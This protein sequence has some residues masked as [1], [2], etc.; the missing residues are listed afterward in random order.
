ME[1]RALLTL[2]YLLFPAISLANL[3]CPKATQAPSDTELINSLALGNLIARP[4]LYYVDKEDQRSHLFGTTHLG[5]PLINHLPA[6]VVLA[7]R[8]SKSLLVE[9]MP[10]G[11]AQL[12]WYNQSQSE[13]SGQ[14]AEALGPAMYKRYVQLA[15]KKKLDEPKAGALKPWA[16]MLVIGSP[17]N[18]GRGL[19]Q[20]ILMQARSAGVQIKAMQHL[21]DIAV[22]LD[23]LS[24]SDQ[25]VMLR[26]TIC[27]SN[28][29]PKYMRQLARIYSF[30]NP[31]LLHRFNH[32]GR[33]SDPVFARFDKALVDNRNTVF[34]PTILDKLKTGRVFI[35]VGAEHLVGVN[36]LIHQLRA[37][38]YTVRQAP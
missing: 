33:E 19:D 15:K 36:G 38:G 11:K 37:Q 20:Q 25:L 23:S 28:V 34:M 9:A 35:S 6:Q 21:G 17:P 22:A 31:S 24:I 5:P 29:L 1:L 30:G 32:W 18:R 26:D 12:A 13:I 10:D 7:L 27:Q 14:L 8:R 3:P 4:M 16:A 2:A